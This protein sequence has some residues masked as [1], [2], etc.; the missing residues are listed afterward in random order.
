MFEFLVLVLIYWTVLIACGLV[1]LTLSSS[2]NWK[3]ER[4]SFYT[5]NYLTIPWALSLVFVL[6]APFIKNNTITPAIPWFVVPIVG[7]SII[8]IGTLYWIYWFHIWPLFGYSV[9][10]NVIVLPDGSERVEYVVCIRPLRHE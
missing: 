10:H 2:S 8:V 5:S 4:T 9:E 6:S 1:Y 7:C 3:N